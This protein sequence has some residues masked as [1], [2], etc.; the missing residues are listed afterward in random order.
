MKHE[1]EFH[2]FLVKEVN[3]NQSGIDRLH[4]NVRTVQEFLSQNL[5]SFDGVELQG[6]YALKTII[7]PHQRNEYDADILLYMKTGKDKKARNYLSEVYNCFQK[8]RTLAGKAKPKTKCVTLEYAGDFHLDVVPCIIRG[9]RHLICNRNT[10]QF[11]LTSSIA[12]RDWFNAK[13]NITSGNLKLATRLLKYMRDHKGNFSIPSILLTTLIGNNVHDNENSAKA[14][15]K[16]NS[17][18]D[19]L[20]IVSRR[21]NS[22]LQHTPPT[23]RIRNPKLKSERLSDGH[24]D[25]DKYNDFRGMFKV[26]YDKMTDAYHEHKERESLR[27]WRVLFGDNFGR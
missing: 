25:K 26:Y 20:L 23:P 13:A 11:E 9:K 7:K 21:I 19:T 16:F 12:Y 10:N 4:R 14:K 6:S 27:K 22:F 18:P 17:L 24:W 2:D 8:D 1:K 3:V 5:D 15:A